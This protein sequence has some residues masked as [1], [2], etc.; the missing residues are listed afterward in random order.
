M[1]LIPAHHPQTAAEQSRDSAMHR[2]HYSELQVAEK[3]RRESC[4]LA[5][6]RLL[7]ATVA[8]TVALRLGPEDSAGAEIRSEMTVTS[9][10]DQ[11]QLRREYEDSTSEVKGLIVCIIT[12]TSDESKKGAT[13]TM[14]ITLSVLDRFPKFF[15]CCKEH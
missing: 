12:A 1:T 14:A 5:A 15:H 3:K 10:Y 11:C 2:C 9:D 7:S 6:D 8:E 4:L 13:V